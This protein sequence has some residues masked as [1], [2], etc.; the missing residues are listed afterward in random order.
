MSVG[1][2]NDNCFLSIRLPVLCLAEFAN[3]YILSLWQ[4]KINSC[5]H[6][7]VG[8]ES[9]AVL[10]FPTNSRHGDGCHCEGIDAILIH[11]FGHRQ[12]RGNSSNLGREEMG[13]LISTFCENVEDKAELL[14]VGPFFFFFYIIKTPW[15][16][17]HSIYSMVFRQGGIFS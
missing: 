17:G 10:V 9:K 2:T 4:S 11:F 3:K 12:V 15:N 13:D 14:T 1:K 5:P 8:A 7:G 16:F 6:V